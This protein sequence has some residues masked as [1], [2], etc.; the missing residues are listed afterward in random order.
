MQVVENWKC[1]GKCKTITLVP[2]LLSFAF[3][4]CLLEGLNHRHL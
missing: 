2:L 1:E 4:L 3:E